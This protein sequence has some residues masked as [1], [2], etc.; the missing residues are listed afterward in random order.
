MTTRE[1]LYELAR[2]AVVIAVITL[3]FV[4]LSCLWFSL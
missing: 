1:I 3:A 2:W 4:G